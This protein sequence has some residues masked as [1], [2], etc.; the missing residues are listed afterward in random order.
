MWVKSICLI[1]IL[2]TFIFALYLT[3]DLN[4][5]IQLGIIVFLMHEYLKLWMLFRSLF[6][7]RKRLNV[8][9]G[10][11]VKC[12]NMSQALFLLQIIFVFWWARINLVLD[13]IRD[14]CFERIL[15]FIFAVLRFG[16]R[17]TI[18]FRFFFFK[19]FLNSSL[20]S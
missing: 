10:R 20:H 6:S 18:E 17:W 13:S 19:E 8:H 3:L 14:A 15:R 4:A 9:L 16:W 1:L 11:G 5:F 2:F 7:W 12:V